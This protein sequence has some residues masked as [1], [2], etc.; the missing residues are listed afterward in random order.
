MS[1]PPSVFL[2]GEVQIYTNTGMRQVALVP[3][4]LIE[5][6]ENLRERDLR[7]DLT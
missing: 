1:I 7:E 5:N 6:A 2:N 4:E 3:W